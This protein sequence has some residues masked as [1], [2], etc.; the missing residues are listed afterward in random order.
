M[1]TTTGSASITANCP[2]AVTPTSNAVT[3]N[4]NN[5]PVPTLTSLLVT[6]GPIATD[7]KLTLYGAGFAAASTVS[8]NG[9]ALATTYTNS[10]SLTA[11]RANRSRVL[12]P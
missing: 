3:F 1:L 7:T 2:A 10:T 9:Q 12:I 8:Y 4:V 11:T 5:P 6:A